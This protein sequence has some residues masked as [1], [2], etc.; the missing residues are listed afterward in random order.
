VQK[1]VLAL[2]AS[3]QVSEALKTLH[4]QLDAALDRMKQDV[5][6]LVDYNQ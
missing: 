5:R 2:L 4:D 3:D 6:D 1:T